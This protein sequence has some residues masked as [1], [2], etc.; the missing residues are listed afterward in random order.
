MQQPKKNPNANNPEKRARRNKERK[1]LI[2]FQE[3]K[4]FFSL[5]FLVF[6][7]C[8]WDITSTGVNSCGNL[9]EKKLNIFIIRFL[10]LLFVCFVC[11]LAF[12]RCYVFFLF[13]FFKWKI[14][15][16]GQ[17]FNLKDFIVDKFSFT[18]P[19]LA[20]VLGEDLMDF[21]VVAGSNFPI[22]SKIDKLNCSIFLPL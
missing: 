22:L 3:R 1:I 5:N 7:S 16:F 2:T 9:T 21:F 11:F 6:L 19:H 15:I 8:S 18:I 20:T 4:Y 17:L 13:L 14:G 10:L 12:Y